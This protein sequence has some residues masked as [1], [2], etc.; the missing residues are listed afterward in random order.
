MQKDF[1][2]ALD[3]LQKRFDEYVKES[4]QIQDQMLDRIEELKAELKEAKAESTNSNPP[5]KALQSNRFIPQS[6]LYS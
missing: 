3:F 6:T 5:K 4:S 1:I 2:T